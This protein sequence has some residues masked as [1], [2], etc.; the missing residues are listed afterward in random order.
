MIKEYL[1]KL[2]FVVRLPDT[3]RSLCHLNTWNAVD[4]SFYVLCFLNHVFTHET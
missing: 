2:L 3:V 4:F 1:A